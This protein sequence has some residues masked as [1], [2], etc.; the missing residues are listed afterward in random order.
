[1]FPVK[2]KQERQIL[3]DDQGHHQQRPHIA[4][5]GIKAAIMPRTRKLQCQD[6][7]HKLHPT[8]FQSVTSLAKNAFLYECEGQ[9]KLQASEVCL[10]MTSIRQKA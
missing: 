3:R 8:S 5:E 4:R 7:V 9:Q 1:M 6:Q 10:A 2:S